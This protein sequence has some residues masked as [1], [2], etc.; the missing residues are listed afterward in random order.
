MHSF[1][2]IIVFALDD[3]II[4]SK[5]KLS[6]NFRKKKMYFRKYIYMCMNMNVN[7]YQNKE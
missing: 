3:L 2:S 4:F 1:V 6:Y 5:K 7:E